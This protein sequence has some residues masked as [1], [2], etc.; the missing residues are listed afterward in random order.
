MAMMIRLIWTDNKGTHELEYQDI[1]DA[2]ADAINLEQDC[3]ATF[4]QIIGLDNGKE[5]T[6]Y[7]YNK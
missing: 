1:Y 4:I 7:T 6:L 2:M 5:E 3:G